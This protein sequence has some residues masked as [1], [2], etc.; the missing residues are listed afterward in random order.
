LRIKAELF[1]YRE[2]LDINGYITVMERDAFLTRYEVDGVKYIQINNFAKHQSPHHTEKSRG[3]PKCPATQAF[4]GKPVLTP[5][6]NGE[7]KVPERSDSLI[8]DSLIPDSP[9][10]KVDG[11]FEQFWSSYPKRKARGAA[12]KAWSKLKDK[13]NTL[14]AILTALAWQRSSQDWT[15]E[16]GQYVP[17]P[18]SYL[19]AQGWLDERPAGIALVQA[20]TPEQAAAQKAE[21]IAI[22]RAAHFAQEQAA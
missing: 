6:S 18:A 2:G 15:K 10:T 21:Q 1:P 12:T 17:Y 16:G 19:N 11:L 13:A 3:Y 4:A 20:I 5:L 9:P 8:P 14:Q 7:C 22:A